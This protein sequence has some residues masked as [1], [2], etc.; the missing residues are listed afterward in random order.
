MLGGVLVVAGAV[1]IPD[2]AAAV[3]AVR[4]YQLIPEPL[5]APVAFGLPVLEVALGL[6]LIAGVLVRAAALAA[7][8]LLVVFMVGVASAWARGLQIDC[9]CFGGGGEVAAGD[10]AYPGE[11][12]RDL[13]LLAVALLLARRPRS[14]TCPAGAPRTAPTLPGAPSPAAPLPEESHAR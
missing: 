6:A 11:L 5:V 7:A 8:V 14:R 9:G 3:R 12:L 1:K 2:P 10:T 4:A 13:G